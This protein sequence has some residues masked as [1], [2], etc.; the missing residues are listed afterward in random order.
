MSK[1]DLNGAKIIPFKAAYTYI[2]HISEYPTGLICHG[3]NYLVICVV[4]SP[5][6]I[7]VRKSDGIPREVIFTEVISL[8]VRRHVAGKR[9]C[10]E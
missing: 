8:A 10:S 4:S 7:L 6:S 2:A 9:V 5:L 1:T 3:F